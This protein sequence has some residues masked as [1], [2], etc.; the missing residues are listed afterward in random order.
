MSCYSNPRLALLI[1][2]VMQKM[3]ILL[4][5]LLFIT[6][7]FVAIAFFTIAPCDSRDSLKIPS[8]NGRYIAQVKDSDCGATTPFIGDVLLTKPVWGIT[9]PW[10]NKKGIFSFKGTRNEVDLFWVDEMTLKVVYTNCQKK[11]S[12]NI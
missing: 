9:I 8:L 10:I 4:P 2:T 1:G 7:L 11:L 5:L 3:R 6:I 12:K